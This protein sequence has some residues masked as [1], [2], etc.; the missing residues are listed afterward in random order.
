M[1]TLDGNK[2]KCL[3]IHGFGGGIFEVKKLAEHLL[4]LNYEVVCPSLKGHSDNNKELKDTK[5]TEWIS[6]AE[7]DLLKLKDSEGEIILIGFS[8]GGLIAFN[9][10]CK[11][12]IKAIVTINTPI[13]YW[14]FSQVLIN[15]IDD[16]KNKRL[17]HVGR[18]LKAKKRSPFS[19]MIQFLLLL[20]STKRKIVNIKCPVLIIQAK[21]D[22]TV[23]L[24]SVDY[25][26]EQ[27]S[28]KDKDIKFFQEGGHQILQSS[29]ARDVFICIE[30][31]L[32]N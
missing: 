21:D 13:F 2:T 4:D 32:K 22:D 27:I 19:A 14:N 20:R 9:L 5:Y 11:H 30:K 10:A 16:I 3:I 17:E 29:K 15:I 1:N 12:N 8:M 31:Y 7:D 25:I 28:S 23:Q 24:K 18:Y 26:K 6:S